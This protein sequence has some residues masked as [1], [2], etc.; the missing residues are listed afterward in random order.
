M[1]I[2]SWFDYL[3]TM[4]IKEYLNKGRQCA[5]I[6]DK[7]GTKAAKANQGSQHMHL[8]I[9]PISNIPVNLTLSSVQHTV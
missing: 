8:L 3:E 1:P 6:V 2:H 4:G 9:S 5:S 7:K